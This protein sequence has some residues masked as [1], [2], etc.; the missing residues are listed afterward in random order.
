MILNDLKKQ[1]DKHS[2]SLSLTYRMWIA[3]MTSVDIRNFPKAANATIS[4]N[5]LLPGMVFKYFDA[6]T[7]T[8]NPN[9]EPGEVPSNGKIILTPS[10]EGISKETLAW[11]YANAGLDFIVVY[12]RCSDGQLFI[13]GDKCSGGLKFTYTAIGK[14]DNGNAGIATK[15]EGGECPEPL[16]FY[17][18]PLPLE[19]P[20][21]IAADATS[22]ALTSKSQYQLG[23]N[24][25]ATTLTDISGVTDAHVGRVIEILGSAGSNPT[26][27]AGSTK[28]IMKN[29]LDFTGS[30]GSRISFYINKTG[31]SSYTFHEVHRA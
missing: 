28:F 16:W 9:V 5:P 27:I 21:A 3:Y 22:F 8:I 4:S 25:K 14:L 17:D 19:D 13:A 10:I 20:E 15:F 18:G 12:E 29:G 26:K 2:K 24:T 7:N 11:V 31:T 23:M 30:A 1:E 6:L